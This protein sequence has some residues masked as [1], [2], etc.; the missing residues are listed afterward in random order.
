LDAGSR[1]SRCSAGQAGA[2]PFEAS[3]EELG[4]RFL[5][6]DRP[7]PE[8][9]G[10]LGA[11][12]RAP[13]PEVRPEVEPAAGGGGGAVVWLGGSSLGRT[14][15][16]LE[17]A[18]A[19]APVAVVIDAP[20]VANVPHAGKRLAF[21]ARSALE[22]AD[23]LRAE[24]REVLLAVADPAQALLSLEPAEV[25]VTDEPDPWVRESIA[26][27]GPLARPAPR[28]LI[29]PGAAGVRDSVLGRFSRW[30]KKAERE[31]L[32]PSPQLSLLD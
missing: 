6:G 18:P 29:A 2:C 9:A 21:S 27:L 24:G 1:S 31:A 20:Y 23:D 7:A 26:R 28:R 19:D 10:P 32:G 11:R 5:G 12:Y 22:T 25:H 15:P 13:E 30:W 8:P 3:Y 14:D 17:A 4:S 16:A